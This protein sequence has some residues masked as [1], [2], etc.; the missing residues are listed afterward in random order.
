M[1]QASAVQGRGEETSLETSI[2]FGR[3]NNEAIHFKCCKQELARA[4]T[5]G[6]GGGSEERW[7]ML[8]QPAGNSWRSS[9]GVEHWN[10]SEQA[11]RLL[12]WQTLFF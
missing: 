1:R 7:T 10:V 11:A 12:R 6:G 9:I 4:T 5:C 8:L 3:G 2:F